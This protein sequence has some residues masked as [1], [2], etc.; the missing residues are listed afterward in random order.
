MKELPRQ[1]LLTSS[2]NNGFCTYVL[3][4]VEGRAGERSKRDIGLSIISGKNGRKPLVNEIL[5]T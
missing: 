4:G 1:L 2:Q 5:M 3:L